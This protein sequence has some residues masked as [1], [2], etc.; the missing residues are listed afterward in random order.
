M[1]DR[2]KELPLEIS[3]REVRCFSRAIHFINEKDE[4]W[5]DLN[6]EEKLGIAEEA[7][8]NFVNNPQ[9]EQ[10]PMQA[11]ANSIY[12]MLENI[13]HRNK[14]GAIWAEILCFS[15]SNSTLVD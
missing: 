7:H 1:R 9:G 14:I 15:F 13:G 12:F 11:F 4:K 6:Q 8:Q 10:E 2:I 3:E 5:K